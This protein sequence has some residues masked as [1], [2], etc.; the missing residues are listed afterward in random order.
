[1]DTVRLDNFFAWVTEVP[2]AC[3]P[4]SALALVKV[5]PAHSQIQRDVRYS[6]GLVTFVLFLWGAV[7]TGQ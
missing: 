6:L 2:H 4:S 1:M 5:G 7:E 3:H